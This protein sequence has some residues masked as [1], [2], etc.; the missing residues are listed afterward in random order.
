M[1]KGARSRVNY[2]E[3]KAAV[4]EREQAKKKRQK[5]N[6]IITLAI[7]AVL[8]VG[9][10]AMAAVGAYRRSG[11][12]QRAQI[13]MKTDNF[14]INGSMMSYLIFSQYANYLNTY[15]NYLSYT[16]LKTDTPLKEQYTTDTDNKSITWFEYFANQA[17]DNMKQLLVLCENAKAAGVELTEVE[18]QAALDRAKQSYENVGRYA[19]GVNQTDVD[20]C[21]TLSM[22]ATKYQMTL[23][24]EMTPS[25]EQ[26]Q[27]YYQKN[28]LNVLKADYY[29]YTFSY[30]VPEEGEKLAEGA[31]SQEAAK[32]EAEKLAAAT[33]VED[34]KAKLKAYLVA[35]H[36]DHGDGEEDDHTNPDSFKV[37]AAAYNKDDE[38]SKWLFDDSTVAGSV[39][40]FHDDKAKTYRVYVL[41]KAKYLQEEETVSVRHLLV[42][43]M[44]DS[45]T[46]EQA[47]KKAQGY[48]D[49]WQ[50][51]EKTEQSFADLAMRYTD[52]GN[53][54]NGGL[55]EGVYPDQ[56]VK[57]FNDWC[58]DEARKSGDVGLVDTDYGTH[59]IYF[60]GDDLPR[61]Q[62]SV[63]GTLIS[64]A[65][66]AKV[67]EMTKALT[68]QIE[69]EL[70][71]NLD[72]Q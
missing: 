11:A 67:E 57:T 30:Q 58:F 47:R 40:L 49:Q 1:G 59:V 46:A 34:F 26:I 64:E 5:R 13:V 15:G 32:A 50:N 42:A 2:A 20:N 16:G 7:V 56:M 72:V 43:T 35:N 62:T 14:E 71:K 60:V 69:E 70:I 55:Y 33:G 61:W 37:T 28:P 19:R 48:Y 4:L 53:Y 31:V 44:E 39:K 18:K 38:A 63:R 22:L 24:G 23:E 27:T 45:V 36:E 17:K 54:Y 41:D 21:L 52:D 3:K 68:I 25:V 10:V 9:I 6:T 65:Y 51:G 29:S 12:E 66:D 8:L